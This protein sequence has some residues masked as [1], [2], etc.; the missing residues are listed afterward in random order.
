MPFFVDRYFLLE[1]QCGGTCTEFLY[2][3]KYTNSSGSGEVV[4]ASV[5]TSG[6]TTIAFNWG[7]V[8]FFFFFFCEAT[9]A[10]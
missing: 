8:N 6:R 3:F 9:G 5:T 2:A 10:W 7:T 4:S 1:A